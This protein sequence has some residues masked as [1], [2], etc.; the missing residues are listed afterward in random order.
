MALSEAE[1]NDGDLRFE[2]S[3]RI[4]KTTDGVVETY[5]GYAASY[6]LPNPMDLVLKAARKLLDGDILLTLPADWTPETVSNL[7]NETGVL[8]ATIELNAGQMAELIELAREIL[9]ICEA[10]SLFEVSDD[11]DHIRWMMDVTEN[12]GHGNGSL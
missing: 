7:A 3:F 4:G 10:N 11:A 2:G 6:S 12:P 9:R 8:G 1:R 5:I